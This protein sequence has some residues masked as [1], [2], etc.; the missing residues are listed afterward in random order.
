MQP[1]AVMALKAARLAAKTISRAFDR[2]DLIKVSEK[3]H[4]DYVTNVDAEVERIIIAFLKESYPRHRFLGEEGGVESG[5]VRNGAVANADA[6]YQWII[7]PIDGT[8]NFVHSI[9][10][11]C[12]SIAC[13]HKGKLAHGVIVDPI[14][15]EAFVASRGKGCRLNNKRVRVRATS[16]LDGAMIAT[17]GVADPGFA[18]QQGALYA[19]MLGA[20]VSLRNSGSAALD[21]AYVA[22]GRLDAMCMRRLQ[23]WDMAAGALM[24][25][26]AGGLLGDFDGGAEHLQSGN[27]IAASP[28]L[29]KQLTPVVRR[30]LGD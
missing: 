20:G 16:I 5:G 25:V 19:E 23:I 21:L 4:N 18:K 6:D 30:H 2:P 11:F 10:H 17:G 24:V 7:D 12:I 29:F 28:G 26:E 13:M 1:M 3:K 8:A 9:P 14:K 15:E 27:I 22:A